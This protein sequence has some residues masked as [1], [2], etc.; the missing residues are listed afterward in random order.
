MDYCYSP[1]Q[2]D[3]PLK[4]W[5]KVKYKYRW[6][7]YDWCTGVVLEQNYHRCYRD[8]ETKVNIKLQQWWYTDVW[9][10]NSNLIKLE[11]SKDKWDY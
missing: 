6:S 1:S 2:K 5:D 11:K 7:V 3:S 8:Y 9:M 4:F 10:W